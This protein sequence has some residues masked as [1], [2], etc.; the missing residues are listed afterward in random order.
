LSGKKRGYYNRALED[1][2]K[3]LNINPDSIDA[4]NNRGCIWIIKGKPDKA[5]ND[6]NEILELD[7][8]NDIAYYNRG[9][10]WVEKEN[11]KKALND[12][13][14]ALKLKPADKRYKDFFT[15]LK[16]KSGQK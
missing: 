12:V 16:K 15:L 9:C 11:I 7:K 13:Q 3:A 14:N 2:N 6:F 5:V 10:A 1:F 8:K 4:L